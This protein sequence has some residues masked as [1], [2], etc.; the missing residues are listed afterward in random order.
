ML[1]TAKTMSIT[2]IAGDS[3]KLAQQNIAPLFFLPQLF[4]QSGI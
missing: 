1:L 2:Q 3:L 4:R